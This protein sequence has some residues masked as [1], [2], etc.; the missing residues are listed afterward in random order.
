MTQ[1]VNIFELHH[2]CPADALVSLDQRWK[3]MQ[4][5]PKDI[6]PEIDALTKSEA[7]AY[8]QLRRVFEQ[9]AGTAAPSL[10]CR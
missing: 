5:S 2:A 3:D 1:S 4:R 8:V 7:S 6:S 10:A 9:E